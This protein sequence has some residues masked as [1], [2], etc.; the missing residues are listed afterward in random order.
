VSRRRRSGGRAWRA[1]WGG[2]GRLTGFETGRTAGGLANGLDAS[3]A[4]IVKL[5]DV[6]LPLRVEPDE[7]M[8]LVSMRITNRARGDDQ[9]TT[10]RPRRDYHAAEIATIHEDQPMSIITRVAEGRGD[11]EENS[12]GQIK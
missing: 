4:R 3:A 11:R 12:E 6:A 1:S 9:A 7:A 2:F 8:D 5:G 10:W